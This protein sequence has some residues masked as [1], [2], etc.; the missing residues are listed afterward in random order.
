MIEGEMLFELEGETPRIIRAEEAF[1]EP[2]GEVMHYSDANNRN[3]IGS[4]FVVTMV[5]TPGKP[6][7]EFLDEEELEQRR[8]LRIQ[9]PE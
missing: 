4:K 3:D 7:P 2:G 6:M 8:H 9:L 1:R 5:C